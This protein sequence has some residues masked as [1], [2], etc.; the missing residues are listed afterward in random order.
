MDGCIDQGIHQG[1]GGRNIV[2]HLPQMP[3]NMGK[4]KG[5]A[6]PKKST[7]KEHDDEEVE[8]PP[9]NN[10]K[11]EPQENQSHA[12]EETRHMDKMC[13]SGHECSQKGKPHPFEEIC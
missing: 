3:R 11:H 1:C 4:G 6:S 9:L 12:I 10:A 5:K 13:W 2:P 7:G 8:P